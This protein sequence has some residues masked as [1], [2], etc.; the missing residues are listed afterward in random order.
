V[1]PLTLVS[2][3]LVFL[4]AACHDNVPFGTVEPISGGSGST[5]NPPP[6]LPEGDDPVPEP[7]PVPPPAYVEQVDN[8]YFPLRP[9]TV[10]VYEGDDE[11][12]VRRDEVRVLPT[13]ARVMD[14]ACTVVVQEVYLDGEAAEVTTFWFVQDDSGNV[15]QFGE[16]SIEIEEGVP[17]ISED[18]WRAG[19][20]GA[21]PWI[22]LGGEP[23]VGDVYVG[24]HPAGMDVYTIVSVT[25]TATTPFGTFADCVAAEETN[26]DDPE[27]ADRIIYAPGVGLVSEESAGGRIDL[28]SMR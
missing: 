8:P 15:W 20:D 12:Q 19:V 28:V 11:G 4:A 26:P 25:E 17:T 14:V 1:K 22:L 24:V 21:E 9:G 16:Q 18:S 10:W 6:L 23:R 7:A 2:L 5:A 13:K 27:D 3:L